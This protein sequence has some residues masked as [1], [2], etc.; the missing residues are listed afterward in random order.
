[1][2]L[3]SALKMGDLLGVSASSVVTLT[4]MS[5]L[6]FTLSAAD[7][8][9]AIAA[10]SYGLKL[11]AIPSRVSTIKFNTELVGLFAGQCSELCGAMHGFMPLLFSAL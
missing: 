1:M 9:H 5:N 2:V 11:D 3:V 4:A 10:P 6:V 7:V 8:I